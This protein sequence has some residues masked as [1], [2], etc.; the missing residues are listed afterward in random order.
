[1]DEN[2]R[3]RLVAGAAESVA[4]AIAERKARLKA[5][6]K[7]RDKYKP[8][9]EV[10][11]LERQVY[12]A[13]QALNKYEVKLEDGEE[14]DPQE[15]TKFLQHQDS[16]RKLTTTLQSLRAKADISKK[17]DKELAQE[18][19]EAGIDK[20]TVLSMYADDP[21]TTRAIEDWKPEE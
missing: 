3:R 6:P 21:A 8:L 16:L 4:A 11:Q 9:T 17:T 2:K 5:P 14:L 13:N 18:M 10:A 20:E 19:L 1:M 7:S 12:L 15:E